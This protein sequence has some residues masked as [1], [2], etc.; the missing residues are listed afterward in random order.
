MT[1]KMVSDI[2]EAHGLANRDFLIVYQRVTAAL[3]AEFGECD[4]GVG[5]D[6]A[7]FWVSLDG[8]EYRLKLLKVMS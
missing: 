3:R 4:S 8:I 7:D 5:E 2:A 6:G 1:E